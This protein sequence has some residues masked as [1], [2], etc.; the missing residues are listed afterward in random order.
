M[1]TQTITECRN[2]F[3][4]VALTLKKADH[5]K[6]RIAQKAILHLQ[7]DPEVIHCSI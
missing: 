7:T 1:G 4:V 6:K 5:I 2:I 3:A